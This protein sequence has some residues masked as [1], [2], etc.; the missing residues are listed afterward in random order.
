MLSFP[1]LIGIVELIFFTCC[2]NFDTPTYVY[3][4]TKNK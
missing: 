3:S 4:S 1:I 2:Y